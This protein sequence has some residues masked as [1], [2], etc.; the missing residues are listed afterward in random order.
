MTQQ[1]LEILI[2]A[3]AAAIEVLGQSLLDLGCSGVNVSELAL[4]TFEAPP[5]LP[6]PAGDTVV[7][8]YFPDN[9]QSITLRDAITEVLIDLAMFFPGLTPAPPEIR[10]LAAEDWASNWQQHFPPFEV[11]EALLIRPSWSEQAPAAGQALLTLDPGQAFGTG[12]HATT[13]LCLDVIAR[14]AETPQGLG[15]VLDVGTGSGILALAA[16]ALSATEVLACEIDPQSRLVARENID[17]NR[18]SEQ[19]TVTD[20]PLEEIDGQFDLILA[21]ILAKENIRLKTEFLQRLAEDGH[22]VLS[23]IL[24]EQ[25]EEVIAA[26]DQ[27]PLTLESVTRQSEWTCLTFGCHD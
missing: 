7:R 27:A 18:L 6:L 3:P 16:A 21:N 4:D 11:G 24:I 22:L 13:S 17:Q 25:E 26:F 20:L 5:E 15:R 2:P 19:I 9:G 8:A 12:T 1:W 23:G 14:L 10:I